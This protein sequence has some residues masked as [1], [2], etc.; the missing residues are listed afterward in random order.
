MNKNFIHMA[1]AAILTIS[2]GLFFAADAKPARKGLMEVTQPDGSVLKIQKTGDE[3]RHLV[4]TEDGLPLVNTAEGYEYLTLDADGANLPSGVKAHAPALRGEKE[5]M[6]IEKFDA[7]GITQS[8]QNR[9]AMRS[10]VYAPKADTRGPGLIDVFPSKGVQKG[11]VVLVE[12]KDVKFKT[13]D[14]HDYYTRMLNEPDFNQNGNIASARDYFIDNSLG[15]FTPQFDVYGP[16]TLANN[17]SYYGGNDKWG[18]DKNP[19]LMPLEAC[20]QLDATVDFKEYDRDGDGYIDNVYV[21]YAGYGE[22]DYDSEDTVWPHSWSLSEAYPRK[23]YTFDG[24]ILD[25]Y[26][27]SNELDGWTTSY[28]RPDGIG[29]FV[30]EFSHVIGLPDLYDTSGASSNIPFTPGEY[31]VL[32]YGPYNGNGCVPPYYGAYER[33]A[34]DWMTPREL[35]STRNVELL[36]MKNNVG[37]IIPTE[38]KNEYYLLE[39]RQQE[40]WDKYIPYHGMLV[41]HIDY[42]ESVFMMNEVNNTKNH[43]YVDLVE[44][45]NRL[46]E[47]T[48]K[49]DPFPGTANVTSLKYSTA[50]YLKSW[51]NKALVI[52]SIENIAESN[53]LI[54]F[55]TVKTGDSGSNAVEKLTWEDCSPEGASINPDHTLSAPEL[56]AAPI[57]V[58]DGNV[59]TIDGRLVL[60]AAS[61]DDL[62]TLLT[63]L[64]IYNGRKL[65]IK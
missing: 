49:G 57:S 60:R 2:S 31:S 12:F 21:F 29:T 33:Y 59:W 28:Y 9:K 47:S 35:N 32:D 13:E 63:G 62:R 20:Q 56:A 11:L 36:S 48:V 5:K 54:S 26:A 19:Q 38:E 39:N 52:N 65:L 7:K 3:Y 6:F 41:W 23:K 10:P 22:A 30:H 15:Q 55:K 58:T 14:P 27:C 8:V 1:L 42:V 37:Y 64:Y 53:G 43:Q 61:A 18:N 40:K 24:V 34:L 16:L 50:P 4:L 51:G 45:D 25:K 46:T 17:M 44:A